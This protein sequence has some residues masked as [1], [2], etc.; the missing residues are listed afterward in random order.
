[1]S[2]KKSKSTFLIFILCASFNLLAQDKSS[3]TADSVKC[4]SDESSPLSL[5]KMDNTAKLTKYL[6]N[7]FTVYNTVA[8]AIESKLKVIK[9]KREIATT[10]GIEFPSYSLC[11]KTY[12][13]V[14]TVLR[15]VDE[16]ITNKGWLSGSARGLSGTGLPIEADINERIIE[17]VGIKGGYNGV[18][19][20]PK[21]STIIGVLEDP[22][23]TL[24][25]GYHTGWTRDSDKYMRMDEIEIGKCAKKK[26]CQKIKAHNTTNIFKDDEIKRKKAGLSVRTPRYSV[27]GEWAIQNKIPSDCVVA[28]YRIKYQK[29]DKKFYSGSL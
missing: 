11:S 24:S 22:I 9:A 29:V 17:Y 16:I 26:I 10:K 3:S 8:E 28:T 21:N 2:L 23:R 5:D 20:F 15:E 1:L 14:A 12:F 7:D 25:V 19:K 13:R 18:L 6:V 27:A 4:E